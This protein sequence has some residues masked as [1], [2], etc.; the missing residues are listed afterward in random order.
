MNEVLS[1]ADQSS[2]LFIQGSICGIC[3]LDNLVNVHK[4]KKKTTKI[5]FFPTPHDLSI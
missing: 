1:Y 4:T 2:F 5:I 3:V